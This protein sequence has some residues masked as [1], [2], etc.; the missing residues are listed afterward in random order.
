MCIFAAMK[1]DFQYSTDFYE[2]N[3]CELEGEIHVNEKDY[4]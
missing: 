1:A 3:S 4:V 2:M